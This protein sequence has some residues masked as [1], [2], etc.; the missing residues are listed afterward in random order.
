MQRRPVFTPGQEEEEEI[1][2]RP[3]LQEE[4]RNKREMRPKSGRRKS[5][6]VWLSSC[7]F[8][9]LRA[10][11]DVVPTHRQPVRE[12]A[13]CLLGFGWVFFSLMGRV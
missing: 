2:T 7:M 3:G 9:H 4:Q 11:S 6:S 8:L 12:Q 10:H 13:A 1:S 5:D